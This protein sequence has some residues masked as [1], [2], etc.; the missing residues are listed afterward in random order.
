MMVRGIRSISVARLFFA[1]SAETQKKALEVMT[2]LGD[3]YSAGDE[4]QP[5]LIFI[6]GI[7]S[8]RIRAYLYL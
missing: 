1:T 2:S 7:A 3:I 4:R 5:Y 8:A 6:K